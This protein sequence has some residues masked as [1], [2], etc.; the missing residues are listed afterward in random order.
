MDAVEAARNFQIE[1]ERFASAKTCL[2]DD[3]LTLVAEDVTKAHAALEVALLN[4]IPTIP[5]R[6]DQ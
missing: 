2:D 5:T 4:R 6:E 3:E 1:R